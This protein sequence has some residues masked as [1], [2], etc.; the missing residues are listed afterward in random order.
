M[1]FDFRNNLDT[2]LFADDDKITVS[3]LIEIAGGL[4][5]QVTECISIRAGGELWWLGG[6]CNGD[7]SIPQHDRRHQRRANGKRLLRSRRYRRG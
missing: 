7:G 1:D 3:G 5:F 6:R 2:A 4:R